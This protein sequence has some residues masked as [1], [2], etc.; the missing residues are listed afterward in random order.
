MNNPTLA[1]AVL[2][3]LPSLA[4][5]E[6]PMVLTAI[7]MSGPMEIENILTDTDPSDGCGRTNILPDLSR[8]VR[9]RVAKEGCSGILWEFAET[10]KE[11]TSPSNGCGRI[12]MQFIMPAAARE[13]IMA[14]GCPTM[15]KPDPWVD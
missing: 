8:D 2:A 4:L 14:N 12:P 1:A 5:A 3:V 13:F 10:I 7:G 9:E 15:L 6:S 11:D